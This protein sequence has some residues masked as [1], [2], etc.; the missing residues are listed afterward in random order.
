VTSVG[1]TI[2]KVYI[3]ELR[4]YIAYYK[5]RYGCHTLK[6]EMAITSRRTRWAGNVACTGGK[7][8]VCR[9]LVEEIKPLSRSR[10]KWEGV[11][12]M[13]WGKKNM[14]WEYV[15]WIYLAQDRDNWWAVVNTV[16][17]R[18]GSIICGEFLDCWND[19]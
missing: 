19:L 8:N 5:T 1:F 11:I 14:G 15:D 10:R 9:V 18:G 13:N 12:K 3:H 6:F 16:M 17:N 4:L 7:R 2:I